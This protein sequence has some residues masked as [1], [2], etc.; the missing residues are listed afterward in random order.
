M[1]AFFLAFVF[2]IFSCL[3]PVKNFVIPPPSNL[4]FLKLVKLFYVMS[5]FRDGASTP[6]KNVFHIIE[7]LFV[8]VVGYI[9][10]FSSGP[11]DTFKKNIA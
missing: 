1:N 3:M 7:K 6:T 5:H 9:Y 2:F 4:K 11:R 10:C 8:V